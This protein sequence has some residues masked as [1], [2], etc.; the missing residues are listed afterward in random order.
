M[1]NQK[2]SIRQ[3]Q[4]KN[5]NEEQEKVREL[6]NQVKRTLADYQNLE[7]RVSEERGE[8]IKSANKSLI[9]KLLPTLEHLDTVLKTAKDQG[10]RSNWLEGIEMIV[11]QFR[12]T[13]KEEGLEPVQ[14]ESFN[15]QLHEVVE[16]RN[17]PEGRILDILSMGYKLN[18]KLVKPAK[19]VVGKE[20]IDKGEEE[21]VKKEEQRGDY[22]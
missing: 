3:V 2:S 5:Q 1:K 13:L 11:K 12:E 22:M 6:E 18:G 9:L 16:V 20:D 21:T 14:C 7:K 10:E 8:W 4:D 15:P 19:V 17:G